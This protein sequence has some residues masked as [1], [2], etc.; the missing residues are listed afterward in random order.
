MFLPFSLYILLL[1]CIREPNNLLRFL[2]SFKR[3]YRYTIMSTSFNKRNSNGAS[4]SVAKL[5][6]KF[7]S[8]SGTTASRPFRSGPSVSKLIEKY[9]L[10]S[11]RP[12][13]GGLSVS[14]P[15]EKHKA[16]SSITASR[17]LSGKYPRKDEK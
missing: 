14:K 5:I 11:S 1:F 17:N 7:E 12:F 9:E 4:P 15:V 16:W 6:W 10:L 2:S 8:M 3:E 13:R